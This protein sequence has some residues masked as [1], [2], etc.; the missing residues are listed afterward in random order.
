MTIPD[1][2]T[3]Q[4]IYASRWLLVAVGVLVT[5]VVLVAVG[6]SAHCLFW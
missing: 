3:G 6:I 4:A 2:P 5:S 1:T